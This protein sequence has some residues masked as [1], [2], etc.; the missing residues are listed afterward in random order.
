MEK[1]LNLILEKLDKIE[2]VQAQMQSDIADLKVNQIKLEKRV[3]NVE[4]QLTKVIE[5]LDNIEKKINDIEAINATRHTEIYM[6]LE[7]M[8]EDI[9]FLKH[10]EHQT[11]EDLFK[12]KLKIAK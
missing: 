5:K 1:I 7:N 10:K 2:N 6:K 3:E 11:E 8:N 12:L 9:I 4:V